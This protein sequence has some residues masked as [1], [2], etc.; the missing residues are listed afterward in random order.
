MAH[1][2]PLSNFEQP[3]A[4]L[5]CQRQEAAAHAADCFVRSTNMKLKIVEPLRV[6]A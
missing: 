5:H 3:V 2:L 4:S 1:Q 6:H